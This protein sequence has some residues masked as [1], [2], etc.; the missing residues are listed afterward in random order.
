MEFSLIDWQLVAKCLISI[1]ILHIAVVTNTLVIPQLTVIPQW[2]VTANQTDSDSCS[3]GTNDSQEDSVI[4]TGSLMQ[5]CSVQ[6]ITSNETAALIE[7]PKGALLYAERKGRVPDCQKKY[8]S[9]AADLHCVFEFRQTILILHLQGDSVNDSSI[10]IRHLPLN[11][12]SPICL[13]PSDYEE[14][15]SSRVSRTSHCQT[16]EYNHAFLCDLSSDY[17]CSFKFPVNCNVTLGKQNVEF[18]C[19]EGNLYSRSKSLIVYP[20]SIIR[21]DLTQQSIINIYGY[22]FSNLKT[23]NELDLAKNKLSVLTEYVFNGL[24][25]LTDLNLSYNDLVTISNG[26]FRALTN[27]KYLTLA[28][29]HVNFVHE[30]SFNESSKLTY[31]SLYQ[32]NLKQLP[33]YLFRGLGNLYELDLGYNIL[34]DLPNKV[35][36]DLENLAYLYLDGNKIGFLNE[37]ELLMELKNLEYLNLYGNQISTLDGNLFRNLKNLTFLE[38][39]WN[40]I[41]S[42]NEKLFSHTNELTYLRIHNNNLTQ[43]PSNL[44]WSLEKLSELELYNNSLEHLSNN[45][46]KGLSNLQVLDLDGNR[47]NEVSKETFYAFDNLRTLYLGHNHLNPKRAGLFGPISQP[48]GGR[49]P[50]PPKISETD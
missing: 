44:F 45:V 18:Q 49:I 7:I 41:T 15:H 26:L 4:F 17:T 13:D 16:G 3:L 50:P 43:L 36:I 5:S 30:N 42:L 2:N 12:S 21:L 48:G 28:W 32:N 33:N 6:L 35:F 38:L 10:I 31:F 22:P 34:T 24:Q 39:S 37:K 25:S 19:N 1:S 47:I 20:S 14:Q 9:F 8:V 27:L 23:L 29:N 11:F 46:F 40:Q